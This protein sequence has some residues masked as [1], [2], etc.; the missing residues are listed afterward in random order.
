MEGEREARLSATPYYNAGY[1][2][3]VQGVCYKL[4][5]IHWH[6][7]AEHV[8]NAVSLSRPPM[9]QHMV[10]KGPGY[11]T[12]VLA[13][14]MSIGKSQM[15]STVGRLIGSGNTS[16]YP[17]YVYNVN[18][19][20]LINPVVDRYQYVGSSTT[21]PHSNNVTWIVSKSPMLVSQTTVNQDQSM[22]PLGVDNKP[23]NLR[24]FNVPIF[25]S[26]S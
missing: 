12:I 20:S 4:D 26:K 18:L 10:F 7:K 16:G 19:G 6:T 11:R 5:N 22:L 17:S 9:E 23:L 14:M 21:W 1:S 13:S 2:I 24:D 8:L 3:S 15:A 25:H